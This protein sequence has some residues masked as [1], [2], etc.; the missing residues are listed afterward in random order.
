MHSSLQVYVHHWILSPSPQFPYALIVVWRIIQ[1]LA[2][3]L[4]S[5]LQLLTL[6]LVPPDGL[7]YSHYVSA[8]YRKHQICRT[9]SLSVQSP[10]FSGTF[11]QTFPLSSQVGSADIDAYNLFRSQV[12]KFSVILEW[13]FHVSCYFFLANLSFSTVSAIYIL[14]LSFIELCFSLLEGSFPEISS[15]SLL[16]YYGCYG[17]LSGYPLQVLVPVG[18]ILLSLTCILGYNSSADIL[19]CFYVGYMCSFFQKI[20]L[21]HK[22]LFQLITF[23]YG[24]KINSS[25]FVQIIKPL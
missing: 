5:S 12:L 20:V 15:F 23:S 2:I 6:C 9:C 25:N 24:S 7:E 1:L 10:V 16:F 8:A 14:P 19:V 3:K 11:I 21:I 17:K 18:F 22:L 4:P 13:L